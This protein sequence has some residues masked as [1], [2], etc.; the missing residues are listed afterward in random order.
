MKAKKKKVA[1]PRRTWQI[2]PRHASE[3][4]GEEVFAS[5]RNTGFAEAR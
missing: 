2:N 5:A 3:I 4:F 1:F